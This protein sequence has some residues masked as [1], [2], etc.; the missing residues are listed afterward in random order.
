LRVY[1]SVGG[2]ASAPRFGRFGGDYTADGLVFPILPLGGGD[3]R[4]YVDIPANQSVATVII[5][6][7]DDTLAEGLE[8][9][10]FTILPDA[11][12]EVGAPSAATLAIS[13]NDGGSI[14]GT[15]F[16]DVN[17]N[18]VQDV[19]R[20]EVGIAGITIYADADNDKILD[21]GERVTTTDADGHYTLANLAA[22]S[23]VVRQILPSGYTQLFPDLQ[24]R[25]PHYA[26]AGPGPDRTE[27]RRRAPDRDPARLDRRHGLQRSG[28]RWCEGR[29]GDRHRRRTVYIDA[30][31]DSVL[32]STE[33]K[34]TTDSNGA[35]KITGLA[36]GTFKVRE[37]RPTGWSQ[38]S[39]ASNGA[40]SVTL[41]A[42]QNVTGKNFF[43]RPTPGGT[44]SIAGNVFHDVNRN[45]K[46]DTGDTRPECVGRLHRSRQRQ[47]ARHQRA[48]RDHG[49]SPATTRSANLA[50]GTYK[51][52]VVL[53]SGYVQTLPTGGFGNNATL[54][55]GQKATGK[56][57]GCGQLI[58]WPAVV[59]HELQRV[60]DRAAA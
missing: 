26:G 32:D 20:S 2:E 54:T 4:P 16:I 48:A 8:H 13:D 36:V 21:A 33:K 50:A 27:F 46:K 6:P 30:D 59:R 18:H 31:N 43:V 15:A 58:P 17:N 52:R 7:R 12:Y 42:G 22:A 19:E 45:A 40:I 60:E 24:L 5:T 57:F 11:A 3:D 34:A 44:A 23:Y 1:F 37:V 41:S 10:V 51:I 39:P 14:S 25:H 29:T 38:T 9:A 55:S 49:F 53:K 28:W 35:Y 56:N 47:G